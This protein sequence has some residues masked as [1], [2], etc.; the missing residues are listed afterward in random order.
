MNPG[1]TSLSGH[2][3]NLTANYPFFDLPDATPSVVE[4]LNTLNAQIG[5]RTY[6]AP[7]NTVLTV[8]G[9]PIAA[10]LQKLANAIANVSF[11]RWIERL[12]ADI[13]ANTPHT[14]PGAAAYVLDGTNNGKGLMVFTRGALRDPGTV[15]NGDDYS[16]T[17]TTQVTF[18]SK[19]KKQDHINYLIV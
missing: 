2:L 15:A 7:G 10:S 14:L 19:Q 8:N 6:T 12:S 17:N 11:I 13:P 9:E 3:T 4:A 5:D 1:D 16:E 18:F